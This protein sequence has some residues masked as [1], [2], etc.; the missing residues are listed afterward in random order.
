MLLL[1]ILEIPTFYVSRFLIT[2]DAVLKKDNPMIEKKMA[3]G[4]NQGLARLTLYQRILFLNERFSRAAILS[5]FNWAD[6]YLTWL[7]ATQNGQVAL[8]ANITPKQHAKRV[9]REITSERYEISFDDLDGDVPQTLKKF[10]AWIT[11]AHKPH[12]SVFSESSQA[13]KFAVWRDDLDV[14]EINPLADF[15]PDDIELAVLRHEI[16]VNLEPNVATSDVIFQSEQDDLIATS[17]LTQQSNSLAR[18]QNQ[19]I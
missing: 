19:F 7:F 16:P 5:N 2:M 11:S 1:F 3:E 8:F 15:T 10:D 12:D 14:I 4:I 17:A 9:L 13:P 6:Q 18:V